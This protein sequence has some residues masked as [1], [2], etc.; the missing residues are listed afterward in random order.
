M[1]DAEA[2]QARFDAFAASHLDRAV[3]LAWRLLG[4]DHGA[5]EDVAQEA[6]LAAYRGLRRFRGDAKLETWFYRILLRK[7]QNHRRWRA[8]RRP[9][10]SEVPSEE[11]ADPRRLA[12]A[13]DP[14]TVAR[15]DA[16]LAKLSAPQRDAFVLVHLEGFTANEAAKVMGKA[17]GTI[18]SHLHRALKALRSE[19]GDLK[20]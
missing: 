8:V 3:R 4:A 9:F 7:A 20:P 10:E 6:F 1:Q 15:I 16:A 13:S 5:A 14:E 12:A 18:K 2:V 11:I 19:L 17:P